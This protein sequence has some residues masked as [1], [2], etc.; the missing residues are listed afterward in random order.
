[1]AEKLFTIGYSG[2]P[3][4]ES[5]IAELRKYGIQILIDVRSNPFSA[6]YEIYNKDRLS[7]ALKQAGIYYC[8]YAKQFG[9]RQEDLHYYRSGRLDFELFAQSPQFLEGI[10]SVEASTAV[11]AFM[12]AEKHPQE[13]HRAILVS[14]AFSNRGHP[15]THITPDGTLTQKDLESTLLDTYFPDRDQE[16]LFSEDV[17]SEEEYIAQAYRLRNDE[18]GFKEE[19]LK[20]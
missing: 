5:F 15:V 2:Y 3:T 13:C 6:Y 17:M 1:M 7:A 8:N 19:E 16:T 11:I 10:Q 20:V 12:C 4:V 9:A 18:I 14:R